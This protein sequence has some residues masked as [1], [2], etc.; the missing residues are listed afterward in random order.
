MAAMDGRT[1]ELGP[2]QAEF[3]RRLLKERKIDHM[4]SLLN[5]FYMLVAVITIVFAVYDKMSDKSTKYRNIL[6]NSIESDMNII[7]N[8]YYSQEWEKYISQLTIYG[9][10]LDNQFE[11]LQNENI[12]LNEKLE[13]VK[14]ERNTL[15]TK[16]MQLKMELNT[17]E[18]K[19]Q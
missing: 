8:E 7:E 6:A 16:L 12:K 3:E 19:K 14:K 4:C 5:W 2:L 10:T 13:K 15:D 18:T 1:G 17:S 11:F 9:K